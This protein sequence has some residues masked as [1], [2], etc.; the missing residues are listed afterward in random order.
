[1]RT[2]TLSTTV[3]ASQ[4][5]SIGNV[6]GIT[7]TVAGLIVAAATLWAFAR[8]RWR[9]TIGSRRFQQRT[10]NKLAAGEHRDYVTS[11]LRTPVF[12]DNIGMLEILR[13]RLPH[14]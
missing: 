8:R 11:L 7:A 13:Y 2:W 9:A 14:T 6:L 12:V 4:Q 1:M 5:V 3:I 10:A